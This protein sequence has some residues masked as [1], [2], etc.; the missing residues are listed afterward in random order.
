MVAVS[1]APIEWAVA[2]RCLPGQSESG[3]LSLVAPRAEG[4]LVAVVDGLGHGPEAATAARVA[5]DALRTHADAPLDVLFRQCHAALL[6]TRGVVM[7]A[8][9]V[10]ADALEWLAVGNVEGVLLRGAAGP[11]PTR[12]RVL[13][14]GGVVGYQLPPLRASKLALAA[15]DVLIVATDGIRGDVASEARP[16]WSPREI[17]D[18]TLAAHARDNDDA[19]VLVI[20]AR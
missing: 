12:E 10:T 19:L 14:R 6:K 3:D 13:L 15:G 17:A 11:A 2:A 1:A 5:I 16:G 8:A 7:T 9:I 18:R 4:T 20:A